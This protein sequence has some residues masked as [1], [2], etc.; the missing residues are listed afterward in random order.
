MFFLSSAL[1]ISLSEVGTQDPAGMGLRTGWNRWVGALQTELQ[2][3]G[4]QGV[5]RAAGGEAATP[6]MW[7]CT[8]WS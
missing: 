3:L 7:F 5:H 4:G 6:T 1:R 2:T 8:T